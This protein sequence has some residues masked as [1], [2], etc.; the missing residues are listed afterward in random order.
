MQR[1]EAPVFQG[2]AEMTK[3]LG[4]LAMQASAV[5][6]SVQQYSGKRRKLENLR[7][8]CEMLQQLSGILASAAPPMPELLKILLQRSQ[9]EARLFTERLFRSMDMLGEKSFQELWNRALTE[10]SFPF[11]DDILAELEALGDVLGRYDLDA[12]LQALEACREKLQK[13]AELLQDELPRA[14]R[15]TFGLLLTSTLMIGILLL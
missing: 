4:F 15:I 7:V 3:L 12:Q 9:G 14:S 10:A 1:R 13:H 8:F 5:L 6:L 11:S 2:D